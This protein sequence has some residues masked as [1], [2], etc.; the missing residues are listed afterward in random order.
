MEAYRPWDILEATVERNRKRILEEASRKMPWVMTYEVAMDF[1][2]EAGIH[3]G[4]FIEVDR[5]VP[6]LMEAIAMDGWER[7]AA[8]YT[9]DGMSLMDPEEAA[10]KAYANVDRIDKGPRMAGTGFQ[11]FLGVIDSHGK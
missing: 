8:H 1:S 5:D 11:L 6:V 7:P 9:K 4:L 2:T 10:R 3:Y